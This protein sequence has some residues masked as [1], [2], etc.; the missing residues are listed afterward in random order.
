MDC[1]IFNQ[2][3]RNNQTFFGPGLPQRQHPFRDVP[4]DQYQTDQV[5]AFEADKEIFTPVIYTLELMT[6]DRKPF[7]NQP[8]GATR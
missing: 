7:D 1:M 8:D 4:C 2:F 5:P 6:A 3:L